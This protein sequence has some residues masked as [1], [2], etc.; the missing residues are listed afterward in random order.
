LTAT[1]VLHVDM[2]AFFASVEALDDPSLAG[3]PLIVGGSGPRGVVA[4]CSYEARAYGVRSAMPSVQARR[5]CPQAI[6]V[7]GRHGRYGEVSAELHRI[8]EAFTPLIEPIALDEAYLDVSGSHLLFGDSTEIAAAIRHRV[9]SELQ[10]D[11]SVGVARTKLIA[12]LAS[13]AAKPTSSTAGVLP[14]RGVVRIDPEDEVRYLHALNVRAIPGVGRQTGERLARFGVSTVG[15]LAAVGEES[16]KRLLGSAAGS[17][18]HALAWGRDERPVVPDR[19][20]KSVSHEETFAADDRDPDSLHRQAVRMA[21]S[22]G[23][24][25]R[26]AGV[27]GRTVTI[28]VRFGDFK[29]ITRSRTIP[30]PTSSGVIVARVAAALLQDVQVNQGVRLLGVSVSGLT[31]R[32]ES[33]PEQLSFDA[34]A[35]SEEGH[36]QG[37]A[38]DAVDNAVDEVRRRF[39]A[40]ALAPASLATEGRIRV[41]QRGD[42]QWGPTAAAPEQA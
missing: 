5:L 28:K 24:R 13:R 6:F 31:A 42:S 30:A 32:E 34:L 7:A 21:D 35:P 38:D 17:Q 10:L 33:I 15:D 18:L 23:S 41:K 8:F 20:L 14:G 27:V 37:R 3:K 36:E 9:K 40:A 19:P 39:G 12:K 22:V 2:D 29:M 11:C 16:L 26:A 4:S 1:D 25:L